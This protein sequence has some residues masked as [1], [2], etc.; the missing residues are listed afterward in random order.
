M[1]APAVPELDAELRFVLSEREV[2][3]DLQA[4]LAAEGYR[5][6][7][8]F[9]SMSDT[10][11]ELRLA[12][13]VAPFSLNPAAAGITDAD[14]R[15]RRV[16]LARLVDA[17]SSAVHRVTEVEKRQAADRSEGAATTVPRSQLIA[18]RIRYEDE[19]GR[20]D[21]RIFPSAALVEHRLDEVSEGMFEAEALSRIATVTN[22]EEDT[23]GAAL[24]KDGAI[25]IRK[26]VKT[27]PLPADPEQ[28]RGRLRTL[29]LSYCIAALKHINCRGLAGMKVGV[30]L[31]HADYILGADVHGMK[32]GAT[33][34]SVPWTVTLTYE[35]EVRK[36]AAKLVNYSGRSMKDALEEARKSTEC[37]ERVFTSPLAMC[38]ATGVSAAAPPQATASKGRGEP[39]RM[40]GG[41]PRKE[42]KDKK[43][44]R[45]KHIKT[46]EGRAICFRFQSKGGC[47]NQKCR[48]VHCC[49]DCLS[50]DHSA[51]SCK[52][53]A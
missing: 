53:T 21:D 3:A 4:M 30:F 5:T 44:R 2:P 29:G 45:F 34:R 32:I 16:N 41:T 38:I 48:F 23:F 12:L 50:T 17:W 26:Q 20:V 15:S 51:D 35:H 25:R 22:S 18:L 40:G 37:K 52:A 11:G 10:K 49:A 47:K 7:G 42:H 8:L 19:A 24:D 1:A 27:L 46:P 39:P 13:Q 6:L 14:A 33:D 31:D 43:Q 28:L 9:A 36:L